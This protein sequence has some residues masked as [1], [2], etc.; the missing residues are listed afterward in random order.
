MVYN[1]KKIIWI[2]GASSGIGRALDIKFASEG[3]TVAASARQE[4]LLQELKNENHNI[5]SYPLDV[6]DVDRCCLVFKKILEDFK[7][8]E[9]CVFGSGISDPKSE[10]QFNLD[11]IKKIMEVNFF[12]TIN[13]INAIYK[14]FSEKKVVK[15]QLFIQLL[16]IG[17]AACSRRLL[18]IEICYHKFY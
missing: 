8:V 14:Y 5:Y 12:G 11:K 10:K 13:S 2:T 7:S 18:C 4:D 3:W 17:G 9:I 15:F 1:S 6:T 16:G